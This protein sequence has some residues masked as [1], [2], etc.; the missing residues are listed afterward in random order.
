[1][2]GEEDRSF[3]AGKFRCCRLLYWEPNLLL[4]WKSDV[5]KLA[6]DIFRPY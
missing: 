4:A 6:I 3:I 2:N 1:M 5:T